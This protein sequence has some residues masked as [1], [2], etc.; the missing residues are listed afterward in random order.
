M[1]RVL[2]AA[3]E[4]AP[5]AKTGG[6]ADVLGSL[7]QALQKLG[8]EVRV[9]LPRYRGVDGTQLRRVWDH[10]P[11]AIGWRRFAC[12]VDEA[13]QGGVSYYFVD[14]P[15]LYDRP[16][17]Y[18]AEGRDFHDNHLRFAVLSAAVFAL[19]R[20]L[21]HPDI[22]HFHDWQTALGSVFLRRWFPR[23]PVFQ[24]TKSLFTIHNLEHQGRF[25]RAYFSELGLLGADG[26]EHFG[27]INFMKG[28]ILFSDFVTT[29]SPTYARE[30]QTPEFGFG[31]DGLLRD[32]AGKLTGILNGIDDN[33]WNPETDSLIAANYSADDT[34][35]KL[36]C[37]MDLLEEMGLPSE[38]R[39]RPLMGIV[40]RLA[41]QKGFS[42]LR[43]IADEVLRE[44]AALVV[45]GTG[46]PEFEEFFR[47]LRGRYPDR[48]GV[49]IGY[50]NALAH[51]IEAGSDIFL[52]PSLF[53]PCGLNQMYS[54]RYGAVPVVRATGGLEDSVDAETGFKFSGREGGGLLD[55]IRAAI[56][57]YRD[58]V[59]WRE[60]MQRGMRKDFSWNASAKRYAELYAA[61]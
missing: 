58:T 30:I 12:S 51:K 50:S 16:G 44:D 11:V 23:D 27:D 49:K 43:D 13:E 6:L 56:A 21:F 26:L 9:V 8:H 18:S 7:P 17:I 4:A 28:G 55:S 31:L 15:E 38:N 2:M 32:Q 53:E 34:S 29:V 42:L 14:C 52:M 20:N 45:L 47:A 40:S 24:R 48:V 61:L 22:L 57:G 60:R 10:L 35:G 54:L 59:E 3:S 36:G 37:K 41:M 39:N 19:A 25:P 46:E 33:E 5:F 1:S